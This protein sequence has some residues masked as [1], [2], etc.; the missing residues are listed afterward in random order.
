MQDPQAGD[1][2]TPSNAKLG[3]EISRVGPRNVRRLVVAT[4]PATLESAC[5]EGQADRSWV[6]IGSWSARELDLPDR[7]D[8]WA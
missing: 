6:K 5:L 8:D 4:D 7:I 2:Y 1:Y 3:A